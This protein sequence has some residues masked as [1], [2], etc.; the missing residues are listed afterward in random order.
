MSRVHKLVGLKHGV[1]KGM[2]LIIANTTTDI[3]NK[4]TK[5]CRELKTYR[6]VMKIKWESKH[7]FRWIG[8]IWNSYISP[9]AW[10][11]KVFW[12]L[13]FLIKSYGPSPQ[14]NAHRSEFCMSLQGVYG[15]TTHPQAH[16]D[17]LGV[18]RLQVINSSP[19]FSEKFPWKEN[20][21]K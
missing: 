15:C 2:V 20:I 10:F 16:L 7:K 5:S 11:L 8:Y 3:H 14:K 17:L 19:K 1:F 12:F 4:V 9:M 13:A 21:L 18:Y 6:K